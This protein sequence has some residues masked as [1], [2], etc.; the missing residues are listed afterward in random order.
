MNIKF[1]QEKFLI[2]CINNISF[3][4]EIWQRGDRLFFKD[5]Q[6]YLERDL[7]FDELKV[8]EA[9]LE[10]IKDTMDEITKSLPEMDYYN[11]YKAKSDKQIKR[12]QLEPER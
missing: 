5:S 2:I 8:L 11:E 1:Y 4:K 3:G 9:A 12:K 6:S 10:K 7:T